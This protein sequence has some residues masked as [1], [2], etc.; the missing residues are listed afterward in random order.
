[1]KLGVFTTFLSQSDG[2]NMK[3]FTV[4]EAYCCDCGIR[5]QVPRLKKCLNNAGNYVE[6]KVM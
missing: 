2:G 4:Q 5:K 1:M 6:N 3:R